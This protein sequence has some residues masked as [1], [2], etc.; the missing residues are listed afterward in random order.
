MID[1]AAGGFAAHIILNERNWSSSLLMVVESRQD[2]RW[3]QSV[4]YYDHV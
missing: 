4:E 2:G 1:V 3:I